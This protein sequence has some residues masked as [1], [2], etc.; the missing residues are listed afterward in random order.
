MF[1]EAQNW[2][3]WRWLLE[4]SKVQATADAATAALDAA[5]KKAMA[6]WGDDLK[7]AYRELEAAASVDG[8]HRGHRHYEK[9]KE[10]AKDVPAAVK[11]AAQ[12]VKEAMDKGHAV[13]RDAEDTFVLAERRMSSSVA[14]EGALKALQTYDL[15]E[16]AIRRAESANRVKPEPAPEVEQPR[17]TGENACST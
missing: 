12:R 17:S 3:L 8:N 15:R 6:A 16:K 14:R 13:R 10:E 5:E 2:S 7:K 9:A 11:A 4:K 1:T